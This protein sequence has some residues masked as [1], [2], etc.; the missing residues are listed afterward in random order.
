[1]LLFHFHACYRN[2]VVNENGFLYNIRML[3][4]RAAS[5]CALRKVEGMDIINDY[6]FKGYAAGIRLLY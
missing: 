3:H 2:L 1:M 4:D 5:M 6:F